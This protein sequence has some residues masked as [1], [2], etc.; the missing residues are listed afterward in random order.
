TLVAH[1]TYP[2]HHAEHAWKETLLVDGDGYLEES[3]FLVGTPQALVSEGVAMLALDVAL[4]GDVD[5]VAQRVFADIGFD[6][7]VWTSGAVRA[8]DDALGG[9]RVNAARKLHVD[10]CPRDEAIAYVERWGLKTREHASG[11]VD[12]VTHPTWRAYASCYTSGRELCGRFVT[13]DVQRFRR[14]LTEQFTTSDLVASA[15]RA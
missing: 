4:G 5:S 12:F 13:G 6:Y 11:L 10:G 8:F 15:T 14:L 3:I 2:G 7:D 9:L 1:E